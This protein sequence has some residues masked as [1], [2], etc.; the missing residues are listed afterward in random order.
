[1]YL[2]H[3][4]FYALLISVLF[5]FSSG[6]IFPPKQNKST[7]KSRRVVKG[8]KTK[9]CQKKARGQEIYSWLFLRIS[10]SSECKCFLWI[11]SKCNQRKPT[12]CSGTRT[13]FLENKFR[14]FNFG[15]KAF[16]KVDEFQL[17]RRAGWKKNCHTQRRV[18]NSFVSPAWTCATT[19]LVI[20]R[21]SLKGNVF[22]NLF[23]SYWFCI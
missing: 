10:T 22:L 5:C 18:S 8:Q 15:K 14:G 1:M 16:E 23:E 6:F 7:N 11:V 2:S 12:D 13:D 9:R 19:Y 4:S 3:K 17:D 21:I 20:R